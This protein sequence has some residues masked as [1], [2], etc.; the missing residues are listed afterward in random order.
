MDLSSLSD[1]HHGYIQILLVNILI[2]NS[3]AIAIYKLL[4]RSFVI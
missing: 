4:N 3:F 1:D 2:I